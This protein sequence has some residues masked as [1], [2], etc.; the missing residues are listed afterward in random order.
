M[1]NTPEMFMRV[2]LVGG[3]P[4]AN[5]VAIQD[6]P[7]GPLISVKYADGTVSDYASTAL[8]D[9][10]D[11]K[12][13][14]AERDEK[15]IDWIENAILSGLLSSCF[16]MDGGIHVTLDRPGEPSVAERER[17]TFRDAIDSLMERYPEP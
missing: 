15:R 17:S 7:Q 4:I 11:P 16:E 6:T 14:W 10:V 9:E 1:K 5:I 2:R 3:H 12:H 13:S 8:Y